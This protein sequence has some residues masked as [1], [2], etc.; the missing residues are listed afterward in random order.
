MNLSDFVDTPDFQRIFESLKRDY[1]E[2][3]IL[4]QDISEREECHKKVLILDDVKSEL[5]AIQ[6]G[7]K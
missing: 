7:D 1:I 2:A 4:A 5:L 6:L 3:W